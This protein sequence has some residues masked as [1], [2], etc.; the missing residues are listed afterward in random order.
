VR[1]AVYF[2]IWISSRGSGHALDPD[3]GMARERLAEIWWPLRDGNS[4]TY[5]EGAF[6]GEL[7]INMGDMVWSAMGM[8]EFE[9]RMC[10]ALSA[11]DDGG[12]LK[13]T[14]FY[15]SGD[16]GVEHVGS[17][18][19]AGAGEKTS[20]LFNPARLMFPLDLE[21]GR[22]WETQSM[23]W[24]VEEERGSGQIPYHHTVTGIEPFSLTGAGTLQ[25]FVI[26]MEPLIPGSG[27]TQTWWF[28]PGVGVVRWLQGDYSKVR[29]DENPFEVLN[30]RTFSFEAD[31]TY[32]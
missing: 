19:F 20:R 17:R 2:T 12:W 30:L 6:T 29:P 5:H 18:S 22:E 8:T 23:T 31:I 28:A 13:S 7:D 24:L 1:I 21:V 32:R 11:V 14:E 4:W 10:A 16:A 26:Q 15:L 25:C 27:E 9:G 3:F